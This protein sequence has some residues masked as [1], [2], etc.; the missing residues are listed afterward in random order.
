[1]DLQTSI[2][3]LIASYFTGGPKAKPMAEAVAELVAPLE[4]LHATALQALAAA[5]DVAH[6]ATERAEKCLEQAEAAERERD[7][8]AKALDLARS[9]LAIILGI[10]PDFDGVD[11]DDESVA[12]EEYTQCFDV[13]QKIARRAIRDVDKVRGAVVHADQATHLVVPAGAG[14]AAAQLTPGP[15][16]VANAATLTAADKAIARGDLKEAGHLAR[17]EVKQ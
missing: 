17:A 8:L 5:R 12:A 6:E 14:D 7:R 15:I 1:M 13:A 10:T 3:A 2:R 9:E 4:G 16:T 11:A